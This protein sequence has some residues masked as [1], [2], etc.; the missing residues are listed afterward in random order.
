MKAKF[1]AL[2]GLLLLQFFLA[3]A[4]A[5]RNLDFEEA[6]VPPPPGDAEFADLFPGWQA[7]AN[8]RALVY[9]DTVMD[10]FL[11]YTLSD[12]AVNTTYGWAESVVLS[13]RHSIIIV[14]SAALGSTNWLGLRQTGLIPAETKTLRFLAT[15]E[16]LMYKFPDRWWVG[17]AID[18]EPV[19]T[20]LRQLSDAKAEWNCDV[21]KFTG[22]TAELEL[23]L[24][25]DASLSVSAYISEPSPWKGPRTWSGFG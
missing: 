15:P 18:G 20:V 6:V 22:K 21:S 13:G 19:P 5:F 23:K 12:A 9:Y 24:W 2:I 8:W 17:V 4:Q 11:C 3:N 10:S 14:A 25:V 1:N 16:S 7:V